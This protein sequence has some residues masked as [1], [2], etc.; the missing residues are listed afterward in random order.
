[1]TS[2]RIALRVVPP[3]SL[4]VDGASEVPHVKMF[5]AEPLVVLGADRVPTLVT[6]GVPVDRRS[7]FGPR[8]AVLLEAEGPLWICD[9]GHHRLVGFRKRPERDRAPADW[10]IGQPDFET[11]A[12]NAKGAVTASSLN[13]PTGVCPFGVGGLAVADAWNHR[14]LIW[15]TAPTASHT[16]PD[17]VLG[18]RDVVSGAPNRGA[19]APSAGSLYWPYGVASFGNHFFVA[20]AENRR[21]LGWNNLPVESGQAADLVLGQASFDTRDEN[22]GGAADASSMRWPH[23]VCLW[24]G[25]L[26]VA[27]AGNNRIMIW[28]IVPSVHGQPAD[29]ILGQ[30]NGAAVDHNQSLYWPRAHTLNM[31]YALAPTDDWLLVAD[32]A[33]SRLVGWHFAD[34]RTGAGAQ[35]LAGQRDFHEKGDNR[36]MPPTFD[37]FCWPYGLATCGRRVVVADSG[38]NRVSLWELAL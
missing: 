20:D 17:L 6:E 4:R 37:S 34:V 24:R 13:V 9:T 3:R 27:D 32:T 35:A 38:N 16:P 23:G 25:Q 5:A 8:G 10:V 33:S 21:V 2:S 36:W 26:C 22:A 18:Q 11:E 12:R 14:V 15:K 29:V 19:N 7:F 31:P 1:M 28:K 30:P